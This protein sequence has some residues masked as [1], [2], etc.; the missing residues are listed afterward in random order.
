VNCL[1]AL[2]YRLHNVRVTR[3]TY[4]LKMLERF[5]MQDCKPC[6]T[7]APVHFK[8]DCVSAGESLSEQDTQRYQSIIGSVMYAMI[9]TRPDIAFVLSELSK[10]V[11]KPGKDN[12]ISA[13]RVLRYLQFLTDY[14]LEFSRENLSY[15]FCFKVLSG[16][17]WWCAKKQS[18]IALSTAEAEYVALS[19][20]VQEAI[21]S[22]HLLKDLG[23]L[24][25]E[26]TPIYEDNHACIKIA[27]NDMVQARTK[28]INI[29]YHFSRQTTKSGEVKLIYCPT[30]LMLADALTKALCEVKFAKFA[31]SIFI[32]DTRL[33][34]SESV[35][36]QASA[37]RLVLKQAHAR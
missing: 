21:W 15:R 17:V 33:D 11:S 29:R 12:L 2:V 18:T 4:I 6:K 31:K 35:K 19:H 36:D 3:K 26:A 30:E 20:A 10:Y 23:Y 28:H 37:A 13:K 14:H 16:P 34:E 7:P 8:K 27:K 5:G 22:R 9:G 24:Q 25:L 32:Q 1:G